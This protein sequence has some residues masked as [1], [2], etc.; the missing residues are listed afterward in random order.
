MKNNAQSMSTARCKEVHALGSG[1]DAPRAEQFGQ[2]RTINDAVACDVTRAVRCAGDAVTTMLAPMS[3][4]HRAGLGLEHQATAIDAARAERWF[5][6]ALHI[7]A[8]GASAL[9]AATFDCANV[10]EGYGAII[11]EAARAEV[12]AAS[13]IFAFN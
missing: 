5:V 10:L 4:D 9:P 1:A 8:V 12:V 7:A 2:V 6:V 3:P 13:V 11:A